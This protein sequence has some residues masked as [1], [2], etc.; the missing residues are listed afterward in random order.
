[1]ISILFSAEDPAK[2]EF[3]NWGTGLRY[4]VDLERNSAKDKVS[5]ES[6]EYY[7]GVRNWGKEIQ[8][9]SDYRA[10]IYADFD[11]DEIISVDEKGD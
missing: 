10:T 11:K 4:T 6:R 7:D 5:S 2:R 1:M 9:Y 3:P 8:S